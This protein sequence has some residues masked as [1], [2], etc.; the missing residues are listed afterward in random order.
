LL[1]QL[2]GLAVISEIDVEQ[3]VLDRLA[4]NPVIGIRL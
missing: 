1:E 3:Q 4:K 2:L